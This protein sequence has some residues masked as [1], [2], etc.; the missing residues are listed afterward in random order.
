[1]A[2]KPQE[3]EAT[4][5]KECIDFEKIIDSMLIGQTITRGENISVTAPKGLQL[6]H[7]SL[8]KEI[9]IQAGWSDVRYNSDQHDGD[10]LNF[11]Y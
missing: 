4:L 1:M 7:F 3:L 2:I 5:A 8:I 10:Y 6:K 11:K 9:Y